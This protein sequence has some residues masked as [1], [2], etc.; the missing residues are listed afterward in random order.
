MN[1]DNPYASKN[2]MKDL[3]ALTSLGE[4]VIKRWLDNRRFKL[5]KTMEIKLKC[6]N[7]NKEDRIYLSNYFNRKT[8]NPNQTEIEAI[9]HTLKCTT[10]KIE[11]WF[12]TQRNNVRPT[13]MKTCPLHG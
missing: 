13:K 9:S 6:T 4:R 11:Q 8:K 10:N 1:R 7:F 12:K 2:E 3:Q 5:R